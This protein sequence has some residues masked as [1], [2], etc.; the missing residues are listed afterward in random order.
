V[1]AF[2][3]EQ[4]EKQPSPIESTELGIVMAANEEQL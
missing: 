2:N 1:I 3:E 4:P